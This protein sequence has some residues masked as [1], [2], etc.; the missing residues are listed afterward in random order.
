MNV[1]SLTDPRTQSDSHRSRYSPTVMF[2]SSKTTPS[3]RSATALASLSRT[4]ARVPPYT[5]LRFVPEGVS[6]V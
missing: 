6:T 1:D 2:P 3:A 5:V 4:F